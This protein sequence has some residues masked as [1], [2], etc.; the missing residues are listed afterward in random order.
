MAH[1]HRRGGHAPLARRVVFGACVTALL[2]SA[3]A[4]APSEPD[5]LA[6]LLARDAVAED[7]PP[8][9][10][11]ADGNI[12]EATVRYVDNDSFGNRFF[13]GLDAEEQTCLIISQETGQW[14]SSCGAPGG[15]ALTAGGVTAWLIGAE[16]QG[17]RGPAGAEATET[18]GGI[19]ALMEQASL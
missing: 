9:G 4:C 10:V 6:T 12:A 1:Q 13:V 5:P 16:P 15:F 2:L 8:R 11:F 14:G 7:A 3:A 17:N 18:L 19:V